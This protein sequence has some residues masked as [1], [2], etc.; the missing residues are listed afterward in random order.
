MISSKPWYASKTLIAAAIT[1]LAPLF[2]PIAAVV[3]A[4]P[5]LVLASISGIFAVLRIISHGK[6]TLVD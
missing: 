2:P 5:S 3:Q 1:S 4:N 6:I